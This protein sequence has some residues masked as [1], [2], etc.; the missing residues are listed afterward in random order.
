VSPAAEVVFAADA[1]VIEG[2]SWLGRRRVRYRDVYGIERVGARLWIGARWAPA[3]LGGE[4]FSALRLD[5]IEGELRERIGALS[6]GAERLARIDARGAPPV[7]VPWLTLGLATAFA[8]LFARRATAGLL[9]DGLWLV[10]FGLLA[11]RWLGPMRLV[12]S[13]G[14]ALA[15]GLVTEPPAAL[16]ALAAIATRA[17][18]AGWIGLL[19]F[20]RV[21]RE[22]AL[23][24]RLRS[25]LDAGAWLAFALEVRWLASGTG[26]L[27]LGLGT[28]T[29]F[30]LAPVLL[31]GWPPMSLRRVGEARPRVP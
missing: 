5:A 19:V 29:G 6:D 11:E 27:G 18:P 31:R 12:A 1:L 24:V 4:T 15:V 9:A 7:H 2:A 22:R 16:G 20:V 13:G 26:A 3:V 23:P 14:A 21:L 28:L 8:L 17:L 30:A 25:A 10:A